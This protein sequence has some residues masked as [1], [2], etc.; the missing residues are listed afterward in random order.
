MLFG[1]DDTITPPKLR[2]K[3]F[4]T[5]DL[6]GNRMSYL[7][8]MVAMCHLT[9]RWYTTTMVGEGEGDSGERVMRQ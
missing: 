2:P 5:V 4:D 9:Q 6:G 8:I 7:T 3:A 1:I